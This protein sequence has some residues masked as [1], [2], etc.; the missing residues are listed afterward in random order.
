MAAVMR[1]H[2][3]ADGNFIEQFQTTGFDRRLWELYLFATFDELGYRR[4]TTRAT[5]HFILT[6]LLG[7]IAIAVTTANTSA[8]GASPLPTHACPKTTQSSPR[9]LKFSHGAR[10]V[11]TPADPVLALSGELPT[12]HQA[13]PTALN[14]LGTYLSASA[15]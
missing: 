1:F 9:S 10:A 15:E 11:T 13:W 14:R 4:N 12:G 8:V 5:P 3:D 6:G 7:Q 2:E